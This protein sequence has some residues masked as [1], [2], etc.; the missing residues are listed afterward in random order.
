MSTA[1]TLPELGENVTAADVLR[2]MVAPGDDVQL[3]QA[4]LELETDKATVEVPSSIAGRVT[5]VK[6]KPGDKVK[7]GQVV[8]LVEA[9]ATAPP[10]GGPP[11]VG[12]GEGDAPDVVPAAAGPATASPGDAARNE[13]VEAA[14][15]APRVVEFVLPELGENVEGGDVTS[16]LVKAGSRIERDQPVIELET[17]KAT[18]EV[19]SSVSGVIREVR[20]T[21][22][23]RVTVGDVVLVV[24]TTETAPGVAPVKVQ[25][26][27]AVPPPG[28]SDEPVAAA[29][30]AA[31]DG[32]LQQAV[33]G[34]RAPAGPDLP[35]MHETALEEAEGD[36]P[37]VAGGGVAGSDRAAHP[38]APAAPSVRRVAREL[39]VDIHEVKGTGAGGRI[40]AEDVKA[41]VK[42]LMLA[43]GPKATATAGPAP[44][45]LPDFSKWG[46]IER[47]PMR[48]V[49]RTTAERLSTAWA[50]IPH[51][52][53]FDLAD[54]TVIEGLRQQ[55]GRRAEAA[56]GKLTVTA[57][58]LKVLGAALKAFPQFNASVDMSTGEIVLKQ[59]VHVGIAVDTD[60]GLLVPVI[61]DVDRKNILQLAAE[62]AAVS[63]KA[64]AGK[65]TIE[66]M[67]GGC[68]TI[69]NLGGIGGTHFTPI[70]NHPE[71]AILGLSRARTEPVWKDGAFVPRLMLPLS[72][73]YDHRA[74]DGAD[75]IR[76]LRWVAEAL[77]QPFLLSLQG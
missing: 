28:G 32:G 46:A 56:G 8:F 50:Q 41:H 48:A 43:G 59:Y 30:A 26:V 5:E 20:V 15:A 11:T 4:V 9:A 47:T 76:F 37:R 35:G 74:I 51:V 64:R 36:A 57:I 38:P 58:A 49:R 53:Q 63:E 31:A 62:L 7:P 24:E 19:P 52:T 1:F 61:R 39:G 65:T 75:G 21:T 16:V 6:V 17:D 29:V 33:Y 40:S 69:T 77:E 42:R 23:R 66:E 72:L 34:R 2:V 27:H 12:G 60:R 68:F 22:G 44:V 71:V 3:E 13:P 55:F 67:Q 14:S 10:A 73:S 70:V 25:Q 18:V 54:I 45:V